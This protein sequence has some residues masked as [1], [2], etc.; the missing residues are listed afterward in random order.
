VSKA[1]EIRRA[2]ADP[3]VKAR[4]AQEHARAR[5]ARSRTRDVRNLAAKAAGGRSEVDE[6]TLDALADEIAGLITLDRHT[7][8]AII[9]E[10]LAPYVASL[11]K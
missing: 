8:A 5:V 3:A 4:L 9:R 1:D 2:F 11:A 6:T 10:M 7:N